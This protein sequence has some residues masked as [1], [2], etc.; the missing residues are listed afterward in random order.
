[1]VFVKEWRLKCG[2]ILYVYILSL[3]NE[4]TCTKET[5]ITI[6][7]GEVKCDPK[8]CSL[9]CSGSKRIKLKSFETLNETTDA[10]EDLDVRYWEILAK[11]C[12]GAKRCIVTEIPE[13]QDSL[14]NILDLEVHVWIEYNCVGRVYDVCATSIG[15]TKQTKYLM[16]YQST[17]FKNV[18][19][20][21]CLVEGNF[22]IGLIDVRLK[23][24]DMSCSS[25]VLTMQDITSCQTASACSSQLDCQD[26]AKFNEYNTFDDS[27]E[28]VIT[29]SGLSA[30]SVPLM[31]WIQL[32]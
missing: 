5:E 19:S 18:I 17:S 2:L 15:P 28:V 7:N 20:C 26:G 16:F 29:L 30:K 9:S 31:V 12:S 21:S 13:F 32:N 11:P 10:W 3:T 8:D 27:T 4:R 6:D 23:K 14:D 24:S 1:M 22:E 25:C